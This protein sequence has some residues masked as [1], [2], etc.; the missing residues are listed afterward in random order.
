MHKVLP[1]FTVQSVSLVGR[2][3]L[4]EI[5]DLTPDIS[6]LYELKKR[7]G[8]GTDTFL[9]GQNMI[10]QHMDSGAIEHLLVTDGIL[11]CQSVENRKDMLSIIDKIKNHGGK[12]TIVSD[13]HHSSDE[14]IR[15]SGIAALTRYSIS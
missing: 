8:M 12:V 10:K 1:S 13:N 6:V 7:M 14:L 2:S 3:A 15:L 11:R 4:N 5:P 9:I